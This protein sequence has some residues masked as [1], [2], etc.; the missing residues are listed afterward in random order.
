M[1]ETVRVYLGKVAL[2]YTKKRLPNTII[3]GAVKQGM[4]EVFI[5]L[6]FAMRTSRS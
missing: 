4:L 1:E 6:V 2:N 5:N 3:L